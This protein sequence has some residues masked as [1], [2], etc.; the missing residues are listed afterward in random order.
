M[1]TNLASLDGRLKK[2]ESTPASTGGGLEDVLFAR[3]STMASKL[4]P[5]EQGMVSMLVVLACEFVDACPVVVS[6]GLA[7][8]EKKA[9]ALKYIVRLLAER[10]IELVKNELDLVSGFIDRLCEASKGQIGINKPGEKGEAKAEEPA[11]AGSST[12]KKRRFGTIRG[13]T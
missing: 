12:K 8:L 5:A 2:L 1:S 3:L 6:A 9:L 7:G 4:D 10:G 13:C 11:T